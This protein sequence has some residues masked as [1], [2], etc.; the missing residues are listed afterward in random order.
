MYKCDIQTDIVSIEKVPR[1]H[2]CI[3]R[4]YNSKYTYMY[5]SDMT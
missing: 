1:D 4:A 2:D 3:T 5:V